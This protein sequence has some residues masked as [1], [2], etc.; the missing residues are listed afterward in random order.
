M[1]A[2]RSGTEV[3]VEQLADWLRQQGHTPVL[4]APL[5]GP[6]GEEMRRRGHRVHDRIE[7]LQEPPDVIHGHHGGPTMTALA[8][9]PA[10]PALFVSHS[11]AAEFDRP[12][13]HPNI[14]RYFAV[15]FLVRE[16]WANG[17]VP[18]DRTGILRN[19]VDM[20]RFPRRAALPD[21]PRRAVLVAKSPRHVE[22]VQQAC[23]AHGIDLLAVGSAVGNIVA[24]LPGLFQEADIVFASGR[25]AAEAAA[26][27]CAVVLVDGEGMHG[28]IR[29]ADIDRVVDLNCGVG[30][31]VH[32]PTSQALSDAIAGY[33]AADAAAVTDTLRGSHSLEVQGQRLIET[34]EM[35]REAGPASRAAGLA[36]A[37]F[38]ESYVPHFGGA[39]A[40]L[41]ARDTRAAALPPDIAALVQAPWDEDGADDASSPRAGSAWASQVAALEAERDS[42]V[43]ALRLER[44][45]QVAAR[46]SEVAALKEEIAALRRS[47]SWRATAPIRSVVGMF[48]GGR[49]AFVSPSRRRSGIHG[50]LPAR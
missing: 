19:P 15:S 14:L 39:R 28:L 10:V 27:G 26:S 23:A 36:M 5:I 21:R 16:R 13:V 2:M 48:R 18:M 29:A 47:T 4:Y 33:D 24:D 38:V 43:A 46:D 40:R 31:L 3:F 6:L 20:D 8:A 50:S 42:E 32:P 41:L 44:D 34:Y 9:F 30:A 25:S 17:E 22:A 7:Q 45:S 35:L 1:L 11:V 37:R 12:P 49:T